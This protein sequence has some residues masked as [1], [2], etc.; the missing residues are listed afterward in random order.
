MNK[1]HI[2]AQ[3]VLRAWPFQRG[4]GRLISK[5]FG[6][7]LFK[8]KIAPVLTTDGVKLQVYTNDLVGRHIYLTGAYERSALEVLCNFAEPGDML[9]DIGANVGYISASFLKNVDRSRVIAVDPQPIVLELLRSNLSQFPNR[10]EIIPAALSDHD[11]TEMFVTTE[12]NLGDAYLTNSATGSYPVQVLAA[13][14]ALADRHFDLVKIDVQ[15]HEE[16]ILNSC[17]ET[18]DRGQPRAIVFEEGGIKSAPS[19]TIGKLFNELGYKVF[20]V[21]KRLF[22][23]VIVPIKNE[24]DCVS[25]DYLAISSK[26]QIP[27]KAKSL[28]AL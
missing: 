21:Q 2:G 15:G 19:G 28:Y 17:K 10:F 27:K 25:N 11:G 26:R 14:K 23:N 3:I 13:D 18:I 16:T 20:G 7:P 22:K 8:E 9:L 6:D 4:I 1:E 5:V 24:S 12:G